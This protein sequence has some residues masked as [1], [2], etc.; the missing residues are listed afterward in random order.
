MGLLGSIGY[1]AAHRIVTP[2][3]RLQ[4]GAARIGRGELTES[5]TI[6]TGAKSSDWRT[7][8]MR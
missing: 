8:S 3:Q 4:E 2:I 5:I 6:R 7:N 1:Y